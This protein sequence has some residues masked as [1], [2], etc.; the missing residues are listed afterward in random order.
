MR[1][2]VGGQWVN[3]ESVRGNFLTEHVLNY[4]ERPNF[5]ETGRARRPGPGPEGAQTGSRLPVTVVRPLT[6]PIAISLST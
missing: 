3:T 4:N 5:E 2:L 6:G 1:S